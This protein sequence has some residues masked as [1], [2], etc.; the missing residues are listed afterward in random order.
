VNVK[1]RSGICSGYGN[2]AAVWGCE[3]SVPYD[4]MVTEIVRWGVNIG[5]L[6]GMI[7]RQG[8]LGFGRRR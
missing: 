5:E 6:S 8:E 3:E 1:T 7:A 4:D 2:G